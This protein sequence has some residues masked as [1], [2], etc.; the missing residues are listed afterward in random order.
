[1]QS[2][3]LPG[4]TLEDSRPVEASRH[5]ASVSAALTILSC[6]RGDEDLSLAEIHRRT[7]ITK[8][9]VMRLAG[10]L[11]QHGFLGTEP[12]RNS[13]RLGPSLLRLGQSLERRFHD[14]ADVLAPL[15][16]KLARDSGDTALFSVMRARGRLCVASQEPDHAVRFTVPTGS[17]RPLHA[18][19][20]GRVLLAFAPDEVLRELLCVANLPA[21]TE[22]TPTD[23]GRLAREVAETR[24]LG[25]AV[26][27]GEAQPDSFAVA[28]P[29]MD[30]D[31]T[32][33]GALSVAG[34]VSRYSPQRSGELVTMLLGAAPAVARS[35]RFLPAG[36][37]ADAGH[38]RPATA[39]ARA[40]ARP[41]SPL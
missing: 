21:L 13:Y 29:V 6:F 22:R 12:G 9:R 16:R 35:L 34:P 38:G 36:P 1:M 40:M 15:L 3:V 2:G 14:I 10:T 19:A 4:E 28:V 23:P 41:T 7:G 18:G 5:V 32:L 25:F 33:L 8:S 17:V 37:R 24:R 31:A 39:I 11:E 20:S 27:Q 26:S 30:D